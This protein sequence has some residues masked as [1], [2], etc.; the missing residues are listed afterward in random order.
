MTYLRDEIETPWLESLPSG[1]LERL[2]SL[3]REGAQGLREVNTVFSLVLS[4]RGSC[5]E[6]RLRA[7]VW[8]LQQH[9]GVDVGQG[10]ELPPVAAGTLLWSQGCPAELLSPCFALLPLQFFFHPCL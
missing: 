9:S 3:G 6:V 7:V 2:S 10:T 1:W 8:P 4:F 5:E